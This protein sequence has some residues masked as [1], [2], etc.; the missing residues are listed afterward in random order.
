MNDKIMQLQSII[1][2][3]IKAI[4]SKNFENQELQ[5]S[6]TCLDDSKRDL[7]LK[8]AQ[9]EQNYNQSKFQEQKNFKLSEDLNHI[10]GELRSTLKHRNFEIENLKKSLEKKSDENKLLLLKTKD[11]S[12]FLKNIN[13][14]ENPLKG[15]PV[16]NPIRIVENDI[17]SDS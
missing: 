9:M 15:E 10:I 1:D 16:L 14:L 7:L 5:K 2:D 3:Q 6:I 8:L 11:T 12:N 13:D 4:K 17:I